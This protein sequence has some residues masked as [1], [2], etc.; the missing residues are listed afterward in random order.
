MMDYERQL[1]DR[2]FVGVA[3]SEGVA[4][5][6]GGLG[7][8]GGLVSGILKKKEDAA[9]A[10]K[11]KKEGVLASAQQQAAVKKAQDA[12][13]RANEAALQAQTETDPNGPKHVEA[14]RL[15]YEAQQ[16][17]QAA[18]GMGGSLSLPGGAQP[19]SGGNWL[20][21]RVGGLPVY[22]WGL[23]TIGGAGL[24]YG[25]FRLLRKKR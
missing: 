11:A 14:R 1:I 13:F 16:L 9:A 25:A 18:M 12:A 21:R 4:L 3:A 23:I 19:S 2:D 24:I 6:S 5:A 10:E 15:A 20:V 22:G 8:L 17:A 7:E